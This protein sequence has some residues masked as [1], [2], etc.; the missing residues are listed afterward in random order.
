MQMRSLLAPVLALGAAGCL[1][2]KGDI[3]LLQDDL[4]SMRAQTAQ[5]AQAQERARARN[6]SL[7]RI[8]LD[9][10]ARAVGAIHDS[11]RVLSAHF[12][13]YQANSAQSLYALGQQ[14]VTLQNR[15]GISQRQIQDLAAQLDTR[16]ARTSGDSTGSDT[17]A[18]QTPG[19]D[20]LYQLAR[21]QYNNG[22]FSTARI[23]FQQILQTYPKYANA[24]LVAL[25]IGSCYEGENNR[26]AAD[27][28]YLSVVKQYPQ[29]ADAPTA[30][31]KYGAS[32]MAQGNPAA[33]RTA[34]QR[35]VKEYPNSDAATLAID[36]LKTLPSR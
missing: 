24:S 9:S 25:S 8:R 35:V 10:V 23:A 31:F 5:Q 27:S 22:A 28:V 21:D 20:R 15:A 14:I 4:T 29:S 26:A 30:L 13:A 2:S 18:S 19:P 6:D 34:W 16:V 11:L 3:R 7:A 1:A 36:R 17:A 33:A 32:Q 12:M